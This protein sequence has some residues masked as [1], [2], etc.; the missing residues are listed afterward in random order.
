MFG[1]L[2]TN[3]FKTTSLIY[4]RIEVDFKTATRITCAESSTDPKFTI[5][6][7]YNYNQKGCNV[8]VLE[9]RLTWLYQT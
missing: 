8:I 5:I 2:G 6:Y 9:M 1:P 4:I 3:N 7:Y